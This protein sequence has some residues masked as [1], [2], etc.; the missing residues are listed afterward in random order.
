MADIARSMAEASRRYER[1]CDES[2]WTD[3][4][5]VGTGGVTNSSDLVKRQ[6]WE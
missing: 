3:V 2:E 1:H 5:I 6:H 4:I